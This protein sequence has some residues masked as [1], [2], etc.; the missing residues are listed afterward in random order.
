MTEGFRSATL[1]A[2]RRCVA[3]ALAL[4]LVLGAAACGDDDAETLAVQATPAAMAEAAQETLDAGTGRFEATMTMEV[5]GQH[6]DVP[7][8]GAFDGAAGRQSA[9]IDMG[10]M[11]RGLGDDVPT[12]LAGLGGTMELVRDGDVLFMCWDLLETLAGSRCGSI[13]LSEVVGTELPLG[14]TDPTSFTRALAGAEGVEE[15]GTETTD[16]VETQHFTGTFKLTTAL[17]SLDPDQAAAL[18]AS[19]E[20]LGDDVEDAVFPFD[21]WVDADGRI[22]RMVSEVELQSGSVSVDQRYFDF[23]DDV[24]IQVPEGDVADLGELFAQAGGLGGG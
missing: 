21:V 16:G 23:G 13:D 15:V 9:E 19:F 10:S 12:Q 11:F 4:P 18:E 1:A 7:M 22:R 6:L 14:S 20:Q 24:D 8:T 5:M 2:V 3:S 17:A